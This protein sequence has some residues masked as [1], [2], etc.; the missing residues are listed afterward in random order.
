L[1]NEAQNTS[2]YFWDAVDESDDYLSDGRDDEE[3]VSNIGWVAHKQQYFSSIFASETPFTTAHLLT[4]TPDASDT[5]HTRLFRSEL[6]LAGSNGGVHAKGLW[7]HGPNQ[8]TTLKDYGHLR[9]DLQGSG[10]P[11]VQLL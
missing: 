2:T 10:H 1:T 5:G 7:Y 11:D 4:K 6:T 9:L 3:T 8:Y